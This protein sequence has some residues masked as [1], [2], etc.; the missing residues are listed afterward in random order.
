VPSVIRTVAV[1][2]LLL[3]AG[4]AAAQHVQWASEVL[5]VSGEA[6]RPGQKGYGADQALGKPNK[7]PAPG[8][9]PCAWLASADAS[10]SEAWIKVGFERPTK[11]VQ[12][13]VAE[14]FNPDAISKIILYDERDKERDSYTSQ[15]ES[16]GIGPHMHHLIINRTTYNVAAVKIVLQAGVVTGPSE[17]DAIGISDAFDKVE[18]EINVAPDIQVGPRENL[19]PGVNSQYDEV[20]PVISPDGKTLYVDR[21]NH[22][23]NIRL[24]GAP[25][26]NR[27]TNNDNIWYSQL[28]ARNNWQALTNIGPPLNNGFGSFVSSVTPDGNT[29]LLGGS[30]ASKP[31][32]QE[33]F[34]LWLTHRTK[35]GWSTPEEVSVRD[36]YTKAQFVEFSLSNDGRS[37]VLSLDRNDSHGKKDLYVSF[38]QD[39]DTWS[40][41]K[42]LGPMVNSPA[43]EATPFIASD[44]KTL[45]FAS[46]GFAGYG[47]M[48][49]YITR[50][51]DDTW[52]HWT[53]PQNLGPQLN[54][55]GWDAYYTV[56]ASGEFAY[57]VST[58]NS[59][60]AGDVF[61]VK[62]PEALKPQAVV[63][64]SGKVLEAKSGKPVGAAIKY[65]DLA[66]GK[67]IG[68]ASTNPTTGIYKIT[69][70]AG[71]NYGYRAEANGYIPISENLD[72]TNEKTYHELE[73]DLTL[74]PFEKGEVVRVNNIFFETGKATLRPESSPE[75][76][77][78]A[79]L[80]KD[81][82]TMEIAIAGH[83]DSVGTP[84]TNLQLSEDRANAV[85]TYL[86]GKGIAAK[87]LR[88]HGY[89][90]TQ[91]IAPN[92]TENGRQQNRRVEFTIVRQ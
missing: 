4:S 43:D 34:G 48:D 21:K 38:L 2:L 40:A 63:L 24:G 72:L 50:R 20:L 22:P 14:N 59:Y 35:T 85:E 90:E 7:C 37:I 61:R 67:E 56:P 8:D 28:D 16:Q 45:Y 77:R 29:L 54:T 79:K 23:Q 91:P 92:T 19:G 30:Y 73:R 76:D 1:F 57:F 12:V 46:D 89:G 82:P 84:A 81:H 33:H 3:L 36:F 32:K 42:N 9:S 55:P 17:I 27:D 15:P 13:V 5:D 53:E 80:L 51:L 6:R 64:I 39:D 71:H 70:P 41:P 83:T 69:L 58:E 75:L 11:I 44:G 25:F 18:A 10:S 65:E 78:I 52:Q 62:L 68:S 88:T 86:I 47:G 31:L 74:V 66:T 49:M 87:R 60:G 26:S